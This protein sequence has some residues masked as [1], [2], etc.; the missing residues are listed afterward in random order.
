MASSPPLNARTLSTHVL[1]TQRGTPAAQM[2]VLLCAY[3]AR[4]QSFREVA[5][6]RTNDAGRI[7]FGSVLSAAPSYGANERGESSSNVYKL[8]FYTQ[9]YFDA[10]PNALPCFYPFVE[11]AFQVVHEA[12]S[13]SS[14]GAHYHVPLILSSFGYSTYRGS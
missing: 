7:N 6:E 5:C 2:Q 3:D 12:A 8:R 4:S 13:G 11:V 14:T 9:S 10:Q 1:D